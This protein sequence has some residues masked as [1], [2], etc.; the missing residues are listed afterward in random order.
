MIDI[1]KTVSST[2][3]AQGPSVDGVDHNRDEIWLLLHP[4]FDVTYYPEF[5]HV[6][7]SFDPDQSQAV[8]V[9][10][11]VG[12][13]KT[14]SQIPAGL[15]RD[16]NAFGITE[17]DYSDILNQDPL[18]NST[19]APE[20]PRYVSLLTTLPYEPPFSATD[21]VPLQNYA[22]DNGETLTHT[23]SYQDS[24]KLGITVQGGFDFTDFLKLSLKEE[25]VF[26]WTHSNITAA[27]TGS[28]QKASLTMGG[29]AFGYSGPENIAVYY[30]T[31]YNTFAFFPFE[32]RGET[33]HGVVLGSNG[34][35]RVGVA[36]TATAGG[37][38][39][40]T[41]TN[42]KGE[43]HFTSQLRGPIVIQAGAVSQQLPRVDTAKSF[44][45]QF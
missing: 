15:L 16:F 9:Y 19:A 1:K 8:L 29:P 39:Y 27:S 37:R 36:V 23:D 20:A 25:N 13:L 17:Q 14:P 24:E 32:A 18:A 42:V 38:Q 21:A 5:G 10:A 22:L 40:H 7:W 33:I 4:K 34:K 11:Y 30:D 44:D 26:T 43:Y 12:W 6:T 3:T 45:F 41:F 28:E 35:P 31:I 2:L